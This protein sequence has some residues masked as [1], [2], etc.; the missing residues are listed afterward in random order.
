[1]RILP[2]MHCGSRHK[3][4]L[5]VG[6]PTIRN[7]MMDDGVGTEDCRHTSIGTTWTDRLCVWRTFIFWTFILSRLT[8]LQLAISY[9]SQNAFYK[10]SDKLQKL[11]VVR[12]HV[13]LCNHQATIWFS[14]D[15]EDMILL[16]E[17]RAKCQTEHYR[18]NKWGNLQE[19]EQEQDRTSDW[20]Q[21][22]VRE[23][24]GEPVN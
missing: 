14:R 23:A 2:T 11:V 10:T 22:R 3:P 4:S 7:H 19:S 9:V 13:W 24:E 1:M 15:L 16:A 12:L 8:K 18:E 20:E 6:V 17:E 21:K 5:C